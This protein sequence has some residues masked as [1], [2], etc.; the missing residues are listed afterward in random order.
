MNDAKNQ[1]SKS[2]KK[3]V[4]LYTTQKFMGVEGVRVHLK[5]QFRR[6]KVRF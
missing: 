5:L 4:I 1:F 2:F 6:Q 3:R